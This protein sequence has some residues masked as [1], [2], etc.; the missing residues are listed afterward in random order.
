MTQ[1]PS[2]FDILRRS[3]RVTSLSP[4]GQQELR[5][6]G[7]IRVS[8]LLDTYAAAPVPPSNHPA[9]RRGKNLA[10]ASSQPVSD[11]TGSRPDLKVLDGGLGVTYFPAERERKRGKSC[12]QPGCVRL[13]DHHVRIPGQKGLQ[14]VCFP[15]LQGILGE[16]PDD[17]GHGSIDVLGVLAA[18]VAWL[19]ILGLLAH[20]G[21]ALT[22]PV[23]VLSV[24]PAALVARAVFRLLLADL[25][26]PEAVSQ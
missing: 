13:G 3:R 9:L 1:T 24:V 22:G 11:A 15:C 12:F 19:A 10:L 25:E 6:R 8:E 16:H 20:V 18:V 14:R 17:A 5:N 23:V 26:Q 7:S 4:E 2:L 21:L